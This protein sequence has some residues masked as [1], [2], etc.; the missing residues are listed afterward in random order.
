MSEETYNAA[1]NKIKTATYGEE[2]RQ[3]IVDAIDESYRDIKLSGGDAELV[4]I[5]TSANY[6]EIVYSSAGESVRTQIKDINKFEFDPNFVYGGV[7]LNSDGAVVFND[8][9][10]GFKCSEVM[11]IPKFCDAIVIQ[12]LQEIT[13][14]RY[15]APVV[16]YS[17]YVCIGDIITIRDRSEDK[18]KYIIPGC[19]AG[20]VTFGHLK[21]ANSRVDKALIIKI[22]SN[23]KYMAFSNLVDGM[24]NNPLKA[25]YYF[26]N[27]N[28]STPGGSEMNSDY[29]SEGHIS[30]IGGIKPDSSYSSFIDGLTDF[31]PKTEYTDK[32]L[33]HDTEYSSEYEAYT[34]STFSA[35]LFRYGLNKTRFIKS[36]RFKVRSRETPISKAVA[37]IYDET[38]NLIWSRYLVVGGIA[39]SE[40][41]V[42]FNDV[43]CFVKNGY[44]IGIATDQYIDV[45]WYTAPASAFNFNQNRT[46][47]LRYATEGKFPDY[48]YV[49]DSDYHKKEW[50]KAYASENVFPFYLHADFYEV[51]S[52][53]PDP[54]PVDKYTD[55]LHMND[56][57]NAVVGYPFELFYKGI[58][59]AVNSDPYEYDISFESSKN[60]GKSWARKY[61]WTPTADDAGDHTMSVSVL[62]NLGEVLTSK[63]ASIKVIEK[64]SSPASS[65]NVLCIGDS[66]TVGGIWPS[67]LGRMLCESGGSPEG[68]GLSNIN[69]IGNRIL[70]GYK[71]VGEG[72]WTFVSYLSSMSDDSFMIINGT[73][74]KTQDDQHSNYEDQNG[75]VW[76]LE[77]INTNS[78]KIRKVSGSSTL[79]ASGTLTHV[80]GGVNTGN[81]VYS[82]SSEAPGNPFWNPNTSKV[83]FNYF[84]ETQG[85]SAIDYCYILLG[86][87]STGSE[88]SSYKYQVRTFLNYI[89]EYS[90]NCKI[91]LIGLQIPSRDGFANN[92]G[93]S[94]KYFDKMSFVFKLE[95]W[96]KDICS[97]SNYAGK[98]NYIQLSGQFD[99]DYNMQSMQANP[100][101]RNSNKISVGSNGVHPADEGYKQIADAVFRDICAKL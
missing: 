42:V 59:K 24:G 33:W 44:S 74:D 1:I 94:W 16:F 43:N 52:D 32:P 63:N 73:F 12:C 54:E 66:L 38:F 92:Y 34:N 39:N 31:M 85:I 91:G 56:S 22:P 90:P 75:N 99:S 17:D 29:L 14:T 81:I 7:S 77:T 89:L 79:P 83:D 19:F 84:A 20:S 65:K 55:F 97:E 26:V 37:Y 27:Q 80:S 3:A 61:D 101:I 71:Y 96:Y 51:Q 35:W 50:Q 78:I 2:V 11:K 8:G 62:N 86:W 18:R 82:S 70:N 93:V 45:P 46:L 47:S 30:L 13:D 49:N 48:D 68:L 25:K 5:R 53:E 40:T 69:F 58:S 60:L 72:G 41:N 23:A 10:P 28:A 6:P 98:V 9:Y 15:I 36:L 88:E 67:E 100:N 76:Y 57:Y 87:N 21:A 4:G 95:Q 64:P